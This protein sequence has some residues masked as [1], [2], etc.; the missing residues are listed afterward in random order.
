[1]QPAIKSTRNTFARAHRTL[2]QLRIVK[3]LAGLFVGCDN[4]ACTVGAFVILKDSNKLQMEQSLSNGLL[5]SGKELVRYVLLLNKPIGPSIQH[6]FP[7]IGGGN[8]G[9]PNDGGLG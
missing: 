1:V 4:C 6:L 2:S 5:D 3:M 7:G 8:G 9:N